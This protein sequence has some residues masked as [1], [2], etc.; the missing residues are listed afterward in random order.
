MSKERGSVPPPEALG[1]TGTT[2]ASRKPTT[3]L[4]ALKGAKTSWRFQQGHHTNHSEHGH[5]EVAWVPHLE[6]PNSGAGSRM[7]S[8][9]SHARS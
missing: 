7:S 8:P 1:A 5:P 6:P 9:G 2:P 4:G 3:V